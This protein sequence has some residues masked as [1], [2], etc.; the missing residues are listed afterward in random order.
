MLWLLVAGHCPLLSLL[1]AAS[2]GLW[3]GGP[4]QLHA[5]GAV[6]FTQS[7]G[8]CFVIVILLWVNSS[9]FS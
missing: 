5:A 2:S 4:F 1:A 6:G 7:F 8:R 9:Y 3:A